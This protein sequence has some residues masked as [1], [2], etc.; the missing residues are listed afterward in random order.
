[1]SRAVSESYEFGPFLLD[2]AGRVLTRDRQVV[3]LA[4][5]TFDLLVLF[6]QH[7]GRAYSKQELMHALWPDTF[8]E[9]ANL[10]FQVSVLRKALGA[11]GARWVETV[12]KHGYRFGSGVRTS[13]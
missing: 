13:A 10:S 3:P 12:P 4:P 11:D 2:P 6:L 1:M 8:V 9:E 7:P 5:K